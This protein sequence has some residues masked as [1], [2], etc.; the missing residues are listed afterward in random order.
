MAITYSDRSQVPEEYTWNL[1]DM[2]ESD[3]A[4]FAEL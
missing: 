4:W 3:E 1:S 2:F